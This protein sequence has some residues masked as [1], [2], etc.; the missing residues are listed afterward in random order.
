MHMKTIESGREFMKSGFAEMDG[1]RSDQSGGVPQ[2]P[3]AKPHARS[4]EV[5]KLPRTDDQAV[6]RADIYACMKDR[7]SRRQFSNQE[8]TPVQLSFLLW[9]TQGVSRVTQGRH[10][11]FRTAPS[12]GARHAFETYI[13][14]NRVAGLAPGVYRYLA[15]THE[16]VSVDVP[17]DQMPQRLTAAT[18]GQGFAARS[19]A[20][21]V[22]TCLPYRGEWRYQHEAHKTMLLDAGHVAQNLYLAAEAIEFGTCAIAAYDQEAT[23]ALLGLDGK[24]EFVVYLAPVGK[25]V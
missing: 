5:Y 6:T 17:W 20:V 9:A 22:W 7:R 16:L 11:T 18:L 23:D 12:A 13:L 1:R 4:D 10:G 3:L 2:P 14:A 24:D 21:F 19:A 8:L 25:P 15:L